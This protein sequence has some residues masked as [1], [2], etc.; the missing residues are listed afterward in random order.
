M[1]VTMVTLWLGCLTVTVSALEEMR[2]S[3][4]GDGP[5]QTEPDLGKRL[6]DFGLGKRA[7]R[8]VNEFKRLPMY[9]FGLG[10]RAKMYSFGLGKRSDDDEEDVYDSYL[11]DGEQVPE[12]EMYDDDAMQTAE[13]R[14]QKMYSFGLGKRPLYDFGLGKRGNKQYSFGLGK[15]ERLYSFGLGKRGKQM[16]GFGLGKRNGEGYNLD[17]REVDANELREVEEGQDMQN[18]TVLLDSHEEMGHGSHKTAKRS[19]RQYSFGLGKRESDDE[20]SVGSFSRQYRKPSYS[21]GLGKRRQ[22]YSFGLGKR[23]FEP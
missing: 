11:D 22:M 14:Q 8:Y 9:D 19:P 7:Y 15:R 21:F 13:K 6:Y 2:Q 3:Q 5:P 12:T 23:S 16:Y 20:T 4:T 10:K 1:T 17:K 18:T